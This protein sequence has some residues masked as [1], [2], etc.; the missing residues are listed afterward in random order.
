MQVL[1][2]LN[3]RSPVGNLPHC[4]FINNNYNNNIVIPAE[5]LL[6]IQTEYVSL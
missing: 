2:V 5:K 6:N 3:I 1:F 4:E